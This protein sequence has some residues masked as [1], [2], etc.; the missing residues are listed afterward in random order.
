MKD[1]KKMNAVIHRGANASPRD[2]IY[3]PTAAEQTTYKAKP[4]DLILYV[5]T[6]PL[7]NF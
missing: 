2:R 5:V 1:V 4:T 6:S 3:V 7:K